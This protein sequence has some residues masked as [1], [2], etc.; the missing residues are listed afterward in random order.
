MVIIIV[1]DTFVRCDAYMVSSE[2]LLRTTLE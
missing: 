1:T 2:H